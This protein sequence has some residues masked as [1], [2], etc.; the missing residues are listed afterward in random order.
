MNLLTL[1]SGFWFWSVNLGFPLFSPLKHAWRPCYIESFSHCRKHPFYAETDLSRMWSGETDKFH[2]IVSFF[3][4]SLMKTV[5]EEGNSISWALKVDKARSK[6]SA[7]K[8]F[9]FL[10]LLLSQGPPPCPPDFLS[11][12]SAYRSWILILQQRTTF[13]QDG[14]RTPRPAAAPTSQQSHW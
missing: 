13:T 9:I 2:L 10:T 6:P 1:F 4:S 3:S 12:F 8:Q 7:S 14:L 11:L 5:R